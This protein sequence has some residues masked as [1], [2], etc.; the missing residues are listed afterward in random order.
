MA[1][2]PSSRNETRG[3]TKKAVYVATHRVVGFPLLE[4]ESATVTNRL[5]FTNLF[6]EAQHERVPKTICR[7]T[8]YRSYHKLFPLDYPSKQNILLSSDENALRA[9]ST[10][11]RDP[12]PHPVENNRGGSFSPAHMGWIKSR[13]IHKTTTKLTEYRPCM[14]M[15]FLPLHLSSTTPSGR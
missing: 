1:H 11:L 7:A 9:I 15:N 12:S 10:R 5:F 13:G 3:S 6:L 14:A 2:A 4:K 8:S